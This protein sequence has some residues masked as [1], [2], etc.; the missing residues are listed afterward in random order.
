MQKKLANNAIPLAIENLP[1]LVTNSN[2]KAIK[3]FK[4]KISEKGAVRP[5]KRF[6]IALLT[7]IQS[8]E[9]LDVLIDGIIGIEKIKMNK[10]RQIS[11]RFVNTFSQ[12]IGAT[13]NF[14]SS[15]RDK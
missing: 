9:D 12:F 13:C 2:S 6:C 4:W 5:G 7:S 11:W 10:I 3:T 1:G 15:K 14:F 8:L